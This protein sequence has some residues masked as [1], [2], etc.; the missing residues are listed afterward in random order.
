[1]AT[2]SQVSDALCDFITAL[3]Y[4]DGTSQPSVVSH[5]V[6]IYPGWPNPQQVDIDMV[7]EPLGVPA[8]SHVAVWPSPVG[9]NTTRHPVQ[10]EELPTPAATYTLGAAGQ[11]ITVA[12]AA[13][14]PYVRQN[15]AAFVN[16]KPYVVGAGAGATPAQLAT[17]LQ[18]LIVAD[19]PGTSVVGAQITLPAGARIGA[20]RVGSTGSV[21]RSVGREEK[22]FWIM[23]FSPN[24]TARAAVS[25]TFDAPLRDVRRLALA[26]GTSAQVTFVGQRD[27]DT[28]EKQRV[29]RRT[30]MF[31]LEFDATITEA[32]P[33][34]VA[35]EV[36]TFAADGTPLNITYS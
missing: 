29:Y 24:P 27:D 21:I 15:L 26:D 22:Q 2:I 31:T 16:G 12:G 18:A 6:K 28:A 5:A 17:A 1:M 23:T 19:V 7:E 34:M 4:P 8:A 11:V 13:P 30:L 25:E 3:I 32:A 14:N 20:L 33:Q 10:R 36:D 35:G 9:R